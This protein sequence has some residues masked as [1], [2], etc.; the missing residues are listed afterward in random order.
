MKKMNF[1]KMELVQGGKLDCSDGAGVAFVAGAT[2]AGAVFFGVGALVTGYTALAVFAW[3][4]HPT[5]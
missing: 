5:W 1:E 4:C 3:A 2:A